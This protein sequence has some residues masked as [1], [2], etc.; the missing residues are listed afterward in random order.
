MFSSRRESALL[1]RLHLP[2]RSP[3]E[4]WRLIVRRVRERVRVDFEWLSS[5]WLDF[6]FGAGKTNDDVS[7][8]LSCG[9]RFLANASGK[10]SGKPVGR[11]SG[12]ERKGKFNECAV[13]D[14]CWL[15]ASQF[16]FICSCLFEIWS[17]ARSCCGICSMSGL[18]FSPGTGNH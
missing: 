9:Q 1:F 16:V 3:I 7:I 6:C 12:R 5:S 4:A 10:C 11:K 8:A 2:H 17:A 13:R 15:R 14:F 18:V